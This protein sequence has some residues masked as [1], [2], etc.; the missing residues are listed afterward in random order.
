[1]GI[2]CEKLLVR[3]HSNG[4]SF[5]ND[6][7]GVAHDHVVRFDTQRDGQF[8][9]GVG[10]CPGAVDHDADILNFF[11]HQ[12]QRV[13]QGGRRYDR[14]SVLIVVEDRNVHGF[15]QRFLDIEAFRGL[16]V[17]QVDSTES[18]LQQLAG[19][20]DFVRVFGVKFY[21]EN[22]DVGKAFEE[23][24]LAFHY[25]FSGQCPQVAE[26]EYRGSIGDNRY[27][28]SFGGI[29]VGVFRI[30]LNGQAGLG[31]AG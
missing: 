24:A 20:D 4:T 13:D 29:L 3:I 2:G 1:M 27:Q 11:I 28:V 10:R 19:L 31:H 7:F 17:F 12:H 8:G 30:F 14:G 15:F 6:P 16:D 21:V 25:R 22:V 18:G 23:D 5:V 26:A 9:A